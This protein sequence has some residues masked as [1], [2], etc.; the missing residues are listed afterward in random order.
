MKKALL[1]AAAAAMTLTGFAA[2]AAP[3]GGYGGY[4]GYSDYGHDRHARSDSDWNRSQWNQRGDHWR[5]DQWRAGQYYSDYR[6]RD[7][8]VDW[9]A[10]HLPRP[11]DG[12]AYYQDDNGDVVMAAIAGGLIGLV[13]GNVLAN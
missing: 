2:T 4:S 1:G 8:M 12:Y 7:R 9:R 5:S 11:R 10:R 13:L 6:R 3:Y